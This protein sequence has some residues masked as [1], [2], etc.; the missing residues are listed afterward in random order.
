M[1]LLITNTMRE[2][3]KKKLGTEGKLMRLCL[4]PYLHTPFFLFSLFFWVGG[5]FIISSFH[6]YLSHETNLKKLETVLLYL[7]S[8]CMSY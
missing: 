4:I 1:A 7:T 3:I 5:G 2:R 6:T 8:T